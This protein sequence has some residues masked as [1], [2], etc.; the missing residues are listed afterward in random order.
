MNMNLSLSL[1]PHNS[2]KCV[3]MVV[4]STGPSVHYCSYNATTWTVLARSDTVDQVI[5]PETH[6]QNHRI[7]EC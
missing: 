6:S 5:T 7:I 4:Y 3:S 1:F 2:E